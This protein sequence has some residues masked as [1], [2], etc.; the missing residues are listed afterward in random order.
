LNTPLQPSSQFASLRGSGILPGPLF[1]LAQC[2]G[3][4]CLF[5]APFRSSAGLRGGLLALAALLLIADAARRRDW[6]SLWPVRSIATDGIVLWL[7]TVLIWCVFSSDVRESFSTFKGEVAIPLLAGLV[8]H[9][10]TRDE[11]DIQR[12]L[13]ALT[14]GLAGLLISMFIDPFRQGEVIPRPWYGGVGPVST[15]VVGVAA[16]VPF[17]WQSAAETRVKVMGA[18]LLLLAAGIAFMSGNRMAWLSFA[19]MLTTLAVLSIREGQT[20]PKTRTLVGWMVA[21]GALGALFFVSSEARF[22]GLVEDKGSVALLMKDN[23]LALWQEV[24]RM[25][26]ERPLTGRGFGREVVEA[27]LVARFTD[28]QHRGLFL[29][30]HNLLFNYALQMGVTGVVAI[31]LPFAALG[32]KFLFLARQ[33]GVARVAGIC[34]CMLLVGVFSK[35][36]TDDFFIRQNALLFWA[37]VGM[38]AGISRGTK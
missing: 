5:V 6:R 11:R 7:L 8:F 35:N 13:V 12:W 26:V 3:M 4:L 1:T 33:T 22:D 29:Q 19:L 10:I 23:R 30:A 34:G 31:L 38:L 24:M 2:C 18:G 28:P 21:I 25:V 20:M 36:M 9:A 17:A 16:L 27:D 15:W 37:A 32:I 14:A